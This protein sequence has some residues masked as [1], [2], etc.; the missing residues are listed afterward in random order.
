MIKV[1]H[2]VRELTDLRNKGKDVILVTSGDT[3]IA[4][5]P[6]EHLAPGEMEHIVLPRVLLDKASETLTVSI[7]EVEKK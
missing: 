1:E 2:L 3:Q 4:K 7:R 5:F 6:R